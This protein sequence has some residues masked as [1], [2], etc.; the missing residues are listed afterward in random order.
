MATNDQPTIDL[1]GIIAGFAQDLRVLGRPRSE[2]GDETPTNGTARLSEVKEHVQG[3]RAKATLDVNS[4]YRERSEA[5]QGVVAERQ[6]R[7]EA[8]A[9]RQRQAVPTSPDRFIVAGRVTDR[10]TGA[11]LPHVRVRV[12]DL[13]RRED[14]VLGYV[15]TDAL[16]YY[17]LEYSAADFDEADQN[18]ETFIEVLDDANSVLVTSSKSFIQKAGQ[19]AF[20]A[21]AVDGEKLPDNLRMAEKVSQG[22]A[23]RQED[24]ARRQR[25]LEH[26]AD[27]TLT[28]ARPVA[29]TLGR[30]TIV[31]GVAGVEA[32]GVR[33]AGVRTAGAKTA[34]ARSAG[35]KTAGAT[36]TGAKA[37]GARTAGVKATGARTAAVKTTGAKATAAEATGAKPAGAKATGA[38]TAAVKTAGAKTT[39]VKATVTRPLTEVKGIGPTFRDK[40][41][42]EGVADAAAVARIEPARLAEMLNIGESRAKT[43]IADAKAVVKEAGKGKRSKG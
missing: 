42:R 2:R 26:R 20:I 25:V 12:T 41:D 18:P 17:R 6:R 38:R 31:A 9:T 15:R 32:A 11:G 36:T 5:V 29:A 39:G 8:Y 33:T 16:G 23:E 19:S 35:V 27:V 21:V 3:S 14:D 7:L 28:V 13:D 34:G 40:L 10:A 22:V 4:V 43:I 24:F 30:P 1:G 37:T